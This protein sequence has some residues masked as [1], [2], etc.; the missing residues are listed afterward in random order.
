MAHLTTLEASA[1]V[2]AEFR[3]PAPTAGQLDAD[4][5]AH[6]ETLVVFGHAFFSSLATFEFLK[7]KVWQA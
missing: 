7:Y 5:V 1:G 2:S 3:K 4:L 6:E